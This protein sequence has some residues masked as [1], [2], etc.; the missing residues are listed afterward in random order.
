[1][2]RMILGRAIAVECSSLPLHQWFENVADYR[3]QCT[4]SRPR[5]GSKLLPAASCRWHALSS[6]CGCLCRTGN[7]ALLL[8]YG[9]EK[10]VIIRIWDHLNGFRVIRLVGVLYSGNLGNRSEAR[11]SDLRSYPGLW[12]N[13][14]K[15]RLYDGKES[16][17]SPRTC[18][19]GRPAGDTLC[20]HPTTLQNTSINNRRCLDLL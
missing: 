9:L 6:W 19:I 12:W 8:R 15:L 16:E 7:M 13:R 4:G 18:S 3:M 17:Y 11:A 2:T 20:A 5:T 14:I 1:M 10:P